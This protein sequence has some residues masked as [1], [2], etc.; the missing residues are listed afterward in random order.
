MS[1]EI[2]VPSGATVTIKDPDDLTYGDRED[3][4]SAMQIDLDGK[5]QGVTGG[6]V[7]AQLERGLVTAGVEAWTVQ[8]PKTNAVLPIPSVSPKSLRQV[9]AGDFA[10][11]SNAV[12]PLQAHLFPEDFGPDP[13]PE[14]PTTP[15][16]A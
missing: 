16:A 11:I 15:S 3:F 9:K 4:L 5:A 6:A 7:M 14:S 10:A 13:D 1:H 8:D 12:R 2:T